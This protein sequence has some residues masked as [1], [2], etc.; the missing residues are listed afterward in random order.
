M[1]APIVSPGVDV[2]QKLD[3]VRRH[4]I[5][6]IGGS[7][8]QSHRFGA[9]V[10]HRSAISSL[11]ETLSTCGFVSEHDLH[12]GLTP[13]STR[14]QPARPVSVSHG[15]DFTSPL[16]IVMKVKSIYSIDYA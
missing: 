15:S 13:S 7:L 5:H 11:L 8:H 14:T 1:A 16:T 4:R 3:S 2:L 12:V 6:S 10:L 9:R